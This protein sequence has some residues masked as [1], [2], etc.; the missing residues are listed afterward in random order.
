ML[1]EVEVGATRPRRRFTNSW[2]MTEME[3]PWRLTACEITPHLKPSTGLFSIS[4][5]ND[6]LVSTN[7]SY[8]AERVLSASETT[9]L[10][11]AIVIGGP[12]PGGIS[13][14]LFPS[15]F[16]RRIGKSWLTDF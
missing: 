3:A 9:N 2:I 13:F 1:L 14:A 12:C 7:I 8:F 6:C 4:F 10:L 15:M 5:K 11:G 16:F